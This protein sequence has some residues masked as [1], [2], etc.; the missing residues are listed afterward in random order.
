MLDVLHQVVKTVLRLELVLLRDSLLVV[1]LL[2]DLLLAA[3][4]CGEVV[5][6]QLQSYQIFFHSVQHVLIGVLE[7]LLL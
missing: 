2:V 7:E 5:G 4:R 6:D 1:F 3:E